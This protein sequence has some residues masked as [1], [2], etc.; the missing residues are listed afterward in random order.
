LSYWQRTTRA[1]PHLFASRHNTV[2]SKAKYV[3]IGSGISGSLTAFELLEAGIPGED[4]VILE[5]REAASGASSRN[6]GHVRPGMFL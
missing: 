1:F 4:L 3:V 5:A 2:P 6:A